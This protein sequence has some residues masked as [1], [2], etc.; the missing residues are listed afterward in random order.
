[1]SVKIF[2]YFLFRLTE[3]VPIFFYLVLIGSGVNLSTQFVYLCHFLIVSRRCHSRLEA[4]RFSIYPAISRFSHSV[5]NFVPFHYVNVLIR[6]ITRCIFFLLHSTLS[7]CLRFLRLEIFSNYCL[8]LIKKRVRHDT[9][10]FSVLVLLFF[11]VLLVQPHIGVAFMIL[12]SVSILVYFRNCKTASDSTDVFAPLLAVALIAVIP[13][14]VPELLGSLWF[15]IGG[16]LKLKDKSL[17]SF[18]QI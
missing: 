17:V 12:L 18:S 9:E 15:L 5:S 1:M 7:S 6:L 2:I 8:S 3:I 11:I 16:H 4:R 14:R 10:P 13:F